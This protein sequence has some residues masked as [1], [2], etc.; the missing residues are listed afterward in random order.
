MGFTF[1]VK[2]KI[3]KVI[4]EVEFGT[5]RKALLEDCA[6]PFEPQDNDYLIPDDFE[7]FVSYSKEEGLIRFKKPLS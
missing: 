7:Q 2:G 4:F 5:Y 3:N 6:I 1:F